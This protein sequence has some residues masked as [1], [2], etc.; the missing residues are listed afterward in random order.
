VTHK[1]AVA[2]NPALEP[3]DCAGELA[4]IASHADVDYQTGR[5]V[6]IEV[7]VH[8]CQECR[9]LVSMGGGRARNH[10]AMTPTRGLVASL[11]RSLGMPRGAAESSD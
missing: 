6:K 10:Y 3:T 1:E 5:P 9:W 11:A 4:E 2:T 8:E 7:K